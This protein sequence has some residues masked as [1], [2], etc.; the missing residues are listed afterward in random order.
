MLHFFFFHSSNL[1]LW[2]FYDDGTL[3]IKII[4]LFSKKNSSNQ[5]YQLTTCFLSDANLGDTCVKQ[6]GWKSEK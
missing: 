4:S 5:K 1:Q 3:F 2:S 6:E